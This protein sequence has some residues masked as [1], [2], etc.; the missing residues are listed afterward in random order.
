MLNL[1]LAQQIS[2]IRK[3]S[4][5]VSVNIPYTWGDLV[6]NVP[7]DGP[8][9]NRGIFGYQL[10]S[11][12]FFDQVFKFHKMLQNLI[13]NHND[14]YTSVRRT[15]SATSVYAPS[16]YIVGSSTNMVLVIENSHIN[17]MWTAYLLFVTTV[18]QPMF[19]TG[20]TSSCK[21]PHA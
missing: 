21:Y 15:V 18:H 2:A 14:A 3:H 5:V 9:P 8:A 20:C 10:F 16:Y 11:I 7:A 19:V 6:I 17:V 12:R 13:W 1:D 4:Y